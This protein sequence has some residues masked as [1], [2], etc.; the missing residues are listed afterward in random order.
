V[1]DPDIVDLDALIAAGEGATVEFK[2]SLRYD[3]ETGNVNKELTKG[4][5]KTMAGF[6][7]AHGGTLL[8]GVHDDGCVG[9]IETDIATL[10]RR[11]DL[12]G[13]QQTLRMV[14]GRH[15]GVEVTPSVRVAF[16]EKNGLTVACVRCDGWHQPVFFQDGERLEFYVRDGNLTRPL[17]VRASYQYIAY[18]WAA[19]TVVD[20]SRVKELVAE[21]LR[22]LGANQGE[23]GMLAPTPPQETLVALPE[24]E[25]PSAQSEGAMAAPTEEAD[26][27]S[28]TTPGGLEAVLA[29]VVELV[30]SDVVG[31]AAAVVGVGALEPEP[32]EPREVPPPWLRV[33]TRRVLN[34][35]LRQLA[36]SHGWKRLYII[37]PWISELAEGASLSFDVLLQRLVED[38]TTV[39]LVTRPPEEPWHEAAVARFAETGRA[40][41]AFVPDLHVK[42]YTAL[43]NQGAFAML[44]SANFTQQSLSNREI[45]LLVNAYLEGKR[46]VKDLNYEASQIYRMPGRTLA[47]KA[48]FRA[49]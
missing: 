25:A 9:G 15:L 27:L 11:Q 22:E 6:L 46:V 23:E 18:R 28:L 29:E 32:L 8:I 17:D 40:N 49:A 36:S 13:F 31:E 12:D 26:G 16:V 48:N 3:L 39:Y 5:A 7:N 24:S 30:E 41:V 42:L 10:S 21:A 1:S 44:G 38:G 43:T 33:A 47:H 20:P 4:V 2:A 34:L 14:L 45:G 37:S 35:F 19:D